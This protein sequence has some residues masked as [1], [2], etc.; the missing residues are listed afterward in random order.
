MDRLIGQWQEPSN[1]RFP[2][3][4]VNEM[5]GFTKAFLQFVTNAVS[6]SMPIKV[7]VTVFE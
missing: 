6:G 7:S 5:Q 2:E 4:A 1:G 3:W